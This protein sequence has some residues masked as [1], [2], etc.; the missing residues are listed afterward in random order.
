MDPEHY[1]WAVLE[2]LTKHPDAQTVNEVAQALKLDAQA[3]RA[4]MVWLCDNSM[5]RATLSG[6]RITGKGWDTLEAIIA[7]MKDAA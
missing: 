1:V 7:G 4:I 5:V 2:Q 6:F 3:I